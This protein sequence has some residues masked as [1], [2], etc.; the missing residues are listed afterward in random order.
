MVQIN[1]RR[2]EKSS[3]L[4]DTRCFTVDGVGG[5]VTFSGG[6]GDVELRTWHHLVVV[7]VLGNVVLHNY[8]QS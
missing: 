7:V 4:L 2:P 5:G 8:Y 3:D 1:A 6:T